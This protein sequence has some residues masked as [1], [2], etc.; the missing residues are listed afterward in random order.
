MQR[1]GKIARL[2]IALR[3][4]LNQR[5]ANNEDGA[6]LL[7]WLNAIPGVPAMLATDFAGEPITKQNLYEWRQGGFLEW[8]TQQEMFDEARVLAT[9][10]GPVSA[11]T[12]HDLAEQLAAVIAGKF[13]SLLAGWDGTEDKAFDAKL[14]VL[15]KFNQNLAIL[16]R[17][18]HSA[19]RLRMEQ[20]PFE[21]EEQR[22]VAE[23]A[24]EEERSEVRRQVFEQ[25]LAR[26]RAEDQ[27]AAETSAAVANPGT[28]PTGSTRPSVPAAPSPASNP[29]NQ[30]YNPPAGRPAAS[31]HGS[32]QA[33]TMPIRPLAR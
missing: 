3:T 17:T 14:R 24:R 19:A 30:N 29:H 5:L 8:E 13:A 20:A 23:A 4:E 18:N 33:Q 31:N 21:R 22:L 1:K 6:K 7:N 16:R 15:T 2:P 9:N 11:T 27:L 28:L 26:K 25:M 32:A 12:N 10:A